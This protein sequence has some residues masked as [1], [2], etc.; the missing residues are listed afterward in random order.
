VGIGPTCQHIVVVV[1]I[2]SICSGKVRLLGLAGGIKSVAV[3]HQSFEETALIRPK[4]K[5]WLIKRYR[6]K[7]GD[8]LAPKNKALKHRKVKL[9]GHIGV[10]VNGDDGEG[11]WD[12]ERRSG[13]RF[14]KDSEESVGS[15]G[16]EE[17]VATDKFQ[18]MRKKSRQQFA[19][20]A[21][22]AMMDV[23]SAVVMTEE[24]H[25]KERD[26][27]QRRKGMAK[28][29]A[30]KA[31]SADHHKRRGFL[32]MDISSDA[33][34][35]EED[36]TPHKKARMSRVSRDGGEN[37][38]AS[39]SSKPA[40]SE[41]VGNAAGSSS[42]SMSS[43]I[44][45]IGDDDGRKGA[46]APSKDCLAMEAK[47][48][49]EFDTADEHSVFFCKASEVQKR[50]LV[51]WSNTARTRAASANDTSKKNLFEASGKRLQIMESGIKI[52]RAWQ[53]RTGCQNKALIEF[54]SQWK[55]LEQ[56]ASSTPAQPFRC[57]FLWRLRLQIMAD[58]VTVYHTHPQCCSFSDS[59]DLLIRWLDRLIWS[60]SM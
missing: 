16:G 49:K 26:R 45:A 3:R 40:E 35:S 12:V 50:L 52:H 37:N 51:R 21:Q 33:S 14:E 36:A 29:R 58:P 43:V 54:D 9:D 42:A 30:K 27:E 24:D 34:D 60:I 47:L 56:F 19:E 6:Q 28:K 25:T 20:L 8:P 23:L 18:T 39:P 15:S 59:C 44:V 41:E 13:G 5:F 17:E 1:W 32:V 48:W 4:D 46:G 55:V 53:L 31:R 57:D 7:F 2:D 11:P 22:G 38:A 10:L